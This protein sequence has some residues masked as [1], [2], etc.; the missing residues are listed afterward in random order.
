MSR[1]ST[2][3]INVAKTS[4]N[5]NTGAVRREFFFRV[6]ETNE[7]LARA[8]YQEL[9]QR[10]PECKI[11]VTYWETLGVDYTDEFNK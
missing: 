3:V 1:E 10:F 2:Y 8:A 6:E 11:E 4:I 7:H 5:P 9:K